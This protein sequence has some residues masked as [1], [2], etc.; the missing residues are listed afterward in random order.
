MNCKPWYRAQYSEIQIK[1]NIKLPSENLD[2][3][4]HTMNTEIIK[5]E[6]P[7]EDPTSSEEQIDYQLTV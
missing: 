7:N 1:K 2:S 6:I 5:Q 3:I 4:F